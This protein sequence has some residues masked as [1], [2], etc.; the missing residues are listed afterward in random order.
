MHCPPMGDLC[1]NWSLQLT[2]SHSPN[3]KNLSLDNHQLLLVANSLSS[4]F[5]YN[6]T[7]P[8]RPSHTGLET[9]LQQL[10]TSGCWR[11][12]ALTSWNQL[13]RGIQCW[14]KNF[15]EIALVTIRFLQLL[16]MVTTYEKC[17]ANQRWKTCCNVSAVTVRHNLFWRV[18]QVLLP[19]TQ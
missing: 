4:Y 10:E 13:Q 3:T 8:L 18:F 14:T 15:L 11:L 12:L 6:V 17:D 19:L 5:Y 2:F 1:R 7:K 16:W 9:D